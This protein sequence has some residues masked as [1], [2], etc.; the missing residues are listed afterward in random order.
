MRIE[1]KTQIPR[2]SQ[3]EAEKKM[4]NHREGLKQMHYEGIQRA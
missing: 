3:Q 4:A 2:A 1:Y